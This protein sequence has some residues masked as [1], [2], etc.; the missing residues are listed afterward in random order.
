MTDDKKAG[1]ALILGSL[2]G[3]LT[4]AIHPTGGSSH[5]LVVSAIAHSLAIA[6]VLLLFMGN[7]GL[8][9]LIAAP[10]RLAFAAIV[11]FGL[12]TVAV[13]IATTVSG[14]IMPNLLQMMTRDTPSAQSQWRITIATIFQI[15]QAFSGVYTVL[16]AIA[17][18]LW[19]VSWIRLRTLDRGFAWYGCVSAPIIALLV[20]GGYI[21]LNVH[22]M[23]A[24]MLSQ[25]IWF[26]GIGLALRTNG[27]KT[28]P[29][30]SL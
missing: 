25:T 23:A 6:S 22:G 20:S 3:V 4:M 7:F 18:T 26:A 21:Q 29:I 17:I 8:S 13:L 11:S 12:A 19:S 28:H 2:G 1:N 14:F 30:N 16:V 10:D 5:L 27:A 9:R 24:V 15:N